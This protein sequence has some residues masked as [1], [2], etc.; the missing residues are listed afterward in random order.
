M[1]QRAVLQQ[2]L[3]Q[4]AKPLSPARAAGGP[5][6]DRRTNMTAPDGGPNIAEIEH[7][8]VDAIGSKGK[9]LRIFDAQEGGAQH[10]QRD[11]LTMVSAVIADW[12]AEKLRRGR[13]EAAVRMGVM[14]PLR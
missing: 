13:R 2:G 11:D 8:A 7:G 5:G 12:L 9:T 4:S 1:S 3:Y 14:E 6:G 10:C